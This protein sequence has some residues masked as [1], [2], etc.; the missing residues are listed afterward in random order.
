MSK[1]HPNSQRYMLT[2]GLRM[3]IVTVDRRRSV[4]RETGR[5]SVVR[6]G[7]CS[8]ETARLHDCDAIVRVKHR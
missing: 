8:S 2:D 6:W 4:R 1:R 3:S 5:T 7:E